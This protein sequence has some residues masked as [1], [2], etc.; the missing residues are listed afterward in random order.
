MTVNSRNLID[1][2]VHIGLA[3]AASVT[4]VSLAGIFALLLFFGGSALRQIPLNEFFFG[5]NWDPTSYRQPSWGIVQLLVGTIMVTALA[6]AIVVPIGVGAAIYLAELAS[7]RVREILKPAIEMIS[8]IPSVVLGLVGLLFFAPKIAQTFGLSSGLGG[9]TAACLVAVSALPTVASMS[10]DALSSVSHRYREASYALG[11][12]RWRTIYSVVIPAARSG[13]LAATM[14]GLG[15]IIG[16]TMIV[17]MVGGNSRAMPTSPFDP[18]R[19]MTAVIAIETKE[20]VT[21]SLHW[22]SLF[23]IGLVL[24]LLTLMLNT[25][26]G[27]LMRRRAIP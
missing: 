23:A 15:R 22:R 27:A 11:A 17:L 24:F 12:G 1:K 2:L 6:M 19:T 20:A 18:V 7:P 3:L 16:E 21:G 4:V 25:A 26:A 8:S 5:I 14:L 10:E 9:L 13:I